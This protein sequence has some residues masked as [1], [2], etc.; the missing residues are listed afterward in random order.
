MRQ[1]MKNR[2]KLRFNVEKCIGCYAC[3]TAC[4]AEH[5]LPEEEDAD[6]N[7][8]IRTVAE[9]DFQKNVC[10][11]CIHCGLCMKQCPNGA[12]YR[13]EEYGLIL[14]DKGK[15]TGCRVCESVCPKG[16]IHYDA[17]GKLEKCDGCI[18]RRREGREPA[19][20]R[21]CCIGAVE[22]A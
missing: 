16:V 1:G 12:I 17:D 22:R 10:E 11:G 13:E 8:T 9:E 18:E 3:Y 19:C 7:I 21:A 20:V 5:H 2:M 15:C 4:I 6:S 14:V